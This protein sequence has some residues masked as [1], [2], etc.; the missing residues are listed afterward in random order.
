MHENQALPRKKRTFRKRSVPLLTLLSTYLLILV[1]PIS[2]SFLFYSRAV[3]IQ[4]VS[5]SEE[6]RNALEYAAVLL[7]ERIEE[8]SSMANQLA[9]NHYVTNFQNQTA[10]FAY[11]NSYSI[12]ET[13][14]NLPSYRNTNEFLYDYFIFFHKSQ[15]VMNDH[16]TYTYPQFYDLY[17]SVD[18][19]A[20]D[21]WAK[22]LE[23]DFPFSTG[24]QKET[25]FTVKNPSATTQLDAIPYCHPLLSHGTNDG[26]ILLLISKQELTSLVSSITSDEKSMVYIEDR[27][28]N[29]VTLLSNQPQDATEIQKSTAQLNQ[30][31][32][33][34]KIQIQGEEML[35][36]VVESVNFKFVALQSESAVL[37]KVTDLKVILL[38]V[39]LLSG[40]ISLAVAVFFAR[41]TAKPL[42]EILNNLPEDENKTGDIFHILKT[43]L[44]EMQTSNTE[45]R[46]MLHSQTPLLKKSFL[47]RAIHSEFSSRE[48]LEQMGARFLP[49]QNCL[50]CILLVKTDLQSCDYDSLGFAAASTFNRLVE[51]ALTDT[52][53]TAFC[54]N[55]NEQQLAIMVYCPLCSIEEFKNYAERILS[56]MRAQLPANL[57]D[58]IAIAGGTIVPNMCQLPESYEKAQQAF[59]GGT[60]RIDSG[61]FWYKE[62]QASQLS[63]YFPND[64]EVKL[65]SATI[66]GNSQEMNRLLDLLFK[67]N[68]HDRH[69]PLS[70]RKYFVYQLICILTKLNEQ[71]D[72]QTGSS[73]LQ[74][75]RLDRILSYSDTSQEQAILSAFEKLCNASKET[76]PTNTLAQLI[77]EYIKE[78]FCEDSIS[79]ASIASEFNMN[80]SYLSYSFKQW[81]GIKLS[82][83]IENLRIQKAKSLLT[84]TDLSIGRI[85]TETGY[86]SSNSFCRAFKRVTGQNASSYRATCENRL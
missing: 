32:I 82:V 67:K 34:K 18:G 29:A 10:P 70:L 55:V 23:Q 27:Q 31:N 7:E 21:T 53:E 83:Y 33:L 79:L 28:G 69:L 1:I 51:Q 14:K 40:T 62:N 72:S 58:S 13:R 44:A 46:G 43:T 86:L 4:Y 60:P 77:Q 56:Q 59:S 17:M 66:R 54:C 9:T 50:Y 5:T 74:I 64:I 15:L 3:N 81:H 24:V 61:I 2:I 39:L 16:L 42:Q 85:A 47:L 75:E 38:S 12:L 57:V 65:T 22:E 48:E 45:L 11:P 25:S 19:I 41:R 52:A 71:I 73:P 20:Y 36:T 63:Y 76:L 78:H 35:A 49:V 84:Q 26:F 6:N 37:K 30:Q 80:E 68:F 8:I